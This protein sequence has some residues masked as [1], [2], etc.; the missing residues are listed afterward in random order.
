[1]DVLTVEQ[2]DDFINNGFIKIE[3]AF[4]R[5]A[6]FKWQS[7]VFVTLKKIEKLI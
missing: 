4:S 5:S 1:M 6:V 7:T 2:I 3:N